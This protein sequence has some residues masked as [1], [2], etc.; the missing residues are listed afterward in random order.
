LSKTSGGDGVELH[1]TWNGALLTRTWHGITV[2]LTLVLLSLLLVFLW[3]TRSESTLLLTDTG[4]S[5]VMAAGT[6][7]CCGRGIEQIRAPCIR[8][9]T[10]SVCSAGEIPLL[11]SSG[12]TA[13]LNGHGH[14]FCCGPGA[15]GCRNVCMDSNLVSSILTSGHACNDVSPQG[16]RIPNRIQYLDMPW[17]GQLQR[18]KVGTR[19]ATLDGLAVPRGTSDFTITVTV[20]PRRDNGIGV[21]DL[22]TL[23]YRFTNNSQFP[24]GLSVAFND[25]ENDPATRLDFA[26]GADIDISDGDIVCFNNFRFRANVSVTFRFIRQSRTLF[27]FANDTQLGNTTVDEIFDLD[28]TLAFPLVIGPVIFPVPGAGARVLLSAV[29]ADL[30]DLMI[31]ETADFPQSSN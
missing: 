13:Y 24:V 6:Y 11:C 1:G 29:D 12:S 22:S 8:G 5:I 3:W 27:M 21:G 18:Y 31:S 19:V 23:L 9:A 16:L 20:T 30:S 17:D 4:S 7:W 28:S 26:V 25:N 2:R 15:L 10:D 14:P